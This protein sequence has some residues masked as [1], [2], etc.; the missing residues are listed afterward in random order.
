MANPKSHK[1]KVKG[2]ECARTACNHPA[3]LHFNTATRA[4][5]CGRCARLINDAAGESLCDARAILMV[6]EAG[7]MSQRPEG[8]GP[9]GPATSRRR[10][11]RAR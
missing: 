7:G 8:V 2:G 3:A 10:V 11:E 4:Y 9:L 6:G 5:Y 1:G